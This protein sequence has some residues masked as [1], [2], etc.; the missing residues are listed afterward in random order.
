[1]AERSKAAVL[2]FQSTPATGRQ[3]TE[4]VMPL[5]C[6]V[7]PLKGEVSNR[8]VFL[9]KKSCMGSDSDDFLESGGM[10]GE[11]ATHVVKRDHR[12]V[13]RRC[14]EVQ[15]SGDASHRSLRFPDCASLVQATRA[16]CYA[17]LGLGIL[18]ALCAGTSGSVGRFQ[19]PTVLRQEEKHKSSAS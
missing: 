4:G 1:V 7:I 11:A 17:P 8:K 18:A 13:N 9:M 15:K 2:M 3:G 14:H 19:R 6:L 16:V 5:P 10:P 12:L